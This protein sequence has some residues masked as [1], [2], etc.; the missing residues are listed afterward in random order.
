MAEA[1]NGRQIID[2]DAD[3]RFFRGSPAGAERPDFD[4]SAWREV[5]VPHDFGVEGRF[6]RN[7]RATVGYL[8]VGE[9]W[10]RKTFTI[11]AAL[12][13]KR[14]VL[15]FDGVMDRSEIWLNGSKVGEHH[16]GYT[17]FQLDV[18]DHLRFG[19]ETNVVTVRAV[20]EEPSS[21]WYAGAG[22][23]RDITLIVTDPIHVA[24]YGTQITTPTLADDVAHGV[25][26]VSVKTTVANE[27]DATANVAVRT[28][29]VDADGNVVA[30]NAAQAA[31]EPTDMTGRL[32]E[33]DGDDDAAYAPRPTVEQTLGIVDPKL[34][35]TSDPYQYLA[36]TTVLAA[37]GETVL[38]AYETRFGLRWITLDP[39]HGLF[40]NGVNMR[41]L[42]MCMHHDQGALG[43]AA[44]P[45][46][47]TRQLEI[48]KEGGV[49][50]IR[51][52]HNPA[53][54]T[55]I[56]ECSR[57]GLL[58]LEEL[59]DMWTAPKNRNDYS[60]YFAVDYPEDLK[61]MILRDRNEPSVFM[62]GMGNEIAWQESELSIAEDL[63][64]RCHLL[65]PT[66]PNSVND[67][68]YLSK[69]ID[70][71]GN[72]IH[73]RMDTRGYSYIG[74]DKMLEVHEK[75]PD[76][77]IVNSESAN[78]CSN[79][80]YYVYPTEVSACPAVLPAID[81]SKY[82]FEPGRKPWD[83]T[84]YELSCY[85]IRGKRG[86]YI[87]VAFERLIHIPFNVGEFGWTGFDYI[88]EP[89]PYIS[90]SYWT[91][92]DMAE[93]DGTVLA[94]LR[95]YYGMVDTAGIPKDQW[96]I[97][98]SLWTDPDDA[99]MVHLLP[100]WNWSVGEAVSVW[101][102][103]NAASAELFLNGRSL[104][105]REF[106][107][108]DT[109]FHLDASH[110]D[111]PFQYRYAK[112]N[113]TRRK[114]SLDWEVPFE[115][116]TIEVVARDATGRIVARDS[117]TT[118]G[119]PA[120][121]R[122]SADRH[123]IAGD[124]KDLSYVTA[125]VTDDIGV[126]VPRADDEV[127]F[128]VEHGRLLGTDNG[129]QTNTEPLQS[130]TH[131]AYSGL[132]VAIVA[133]DGSGLP[134]RVTAR[135]KGLKKASCVIA[136]A[137]TV[138]AGDVVDVE[139]VAVRTV[140]GVAP[141]LP[142]T[143]AVRFGDGSCRDVPVTWD[144]IDDDAYGKPDTFRVRGVIDCGDDVSRETF[145]DVV[146][147]TVDAVV[148]V[149]LTVAGDDGI[150]DRPVE[151]PDEVA[152][153]TS[154]GG[155][156]RLPVTWEGWPDGVG[157]A[158][159]DVVAVS[160]TVAV[161]G[162]ASGPSQSLTAHASVR[163]LA[164]GERPVNEP[165][166]TA[167]RINGKSVADFNPERTEYTLT[168]RYDQPKPIIEAEA[169]GNN[170][171]YILPPSNWPNGAYRVHVTGEDGK[172][173]RVYT[174]GLDIAPAPV[175]NVSIN[176]TVADPVEDTIVPL[177]VTATDTN[178]LP[179]DLD[180]AHVVVDSSD[181]AVLAVGDP[182]ADRAASSAGGDDHAL[183]AVL[184]GT[185][186]VTA[187]VT[188]GDATVTSAPLPITVTH[189]AQVKQPVVARDV[190]LRTV[191]GEMP[192]LPTTT[193]VSFD[194]GFDAE[195]PVDWQPIPS[196]ALAEPGLVTVTGTVGDTGLT[197][198]ATIVVVAVS[199][200]SNVSVATITHI[201]PDLAET[202]PTVAVYWSDGLKEE[203]PVVWD[204]IDET[205]VAVQGEFTVEGTVDG[206]TGRRA[207]AHVRVT[208]DHV[209]NRDLF[210]FRNDVYPQVSASYTNP[211]PKAQEDVADLM[212]GTVSYTA[213]PGY[214]LKNRWSTAGDP[215]RTAWLEY[216]FGYGEETP[217]MLDSFT[218][219]YCLDGDGVVLPEHVEVE[220]LDADGSA[221]A[222]VDGAASWKPV[223]GL[224]VT[225]HPVEQK[226]DA[227]WAYATVGDKPGSEMVSH[228]DE[229]TYAFEMVRTSRIRIT[230]HTDDGEVVAITEVRGDAQIPAAHGD[231]ELAGIL[232]GGEPVSFDPDVTTYASGASG[233]PG[234][235]SQVTVEPVPVAGSNAAITVVPPAV[236]SDE[237]RIIV[238]SEDH[239]T[240]RTYTVTTAAG[241]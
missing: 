101:A 146:V 37:D 9:G 232:V 44:Y 100:H 187:T 233:V 1:S 65:D 175:A 114:L 42:G 208:D 211:D 77:V 112:V 61:A 157:A 32:V 124:G 69:G 64:R 140:V 145:A 182:A 91:K 174:I 29:I 18:T 222:S 142:A 39:Q 27:T 241:R 63:T 23:Y 237:T 164:D 119:S 35:S 109:D 161:P 6:S 197:A 36:K 192:A 78:I 189:G 60:N 170:L 163:I 85:N 123:V 104:G 93:S 45:R 218:V 229:T 144:A 21:R 130:A 191:T 200:V 26:N 51:T 193:T 134:I 225:H 162:G 236:G 52:S 226:N 224:S 55:Q 186:N 217:F 173:G 74:K 24:Q 198:R 3:W 235:G 12:A 219:Y 148:P 204:A 201:V 183:A 199:A 2:F 131:R 154:D 149:A 220:Y 141:T 206:L 209:Q 227:A 34:W 153:I 167:L 238:T 58:V 95:S 113:P 151:L 106:D 4:D 17:A 22:L 190:S 83:D 59:T 212:D 66:R 99:P 11:P 25:A 49:N 231:A 40:L 96:Y 33:S 79:R 110:A 176:A 117:K 172:R 50:A 168:Q 41:A 160:G 132:V 158:G 139:P 30:E 88:G 75:N 216:R 47:V 16:Y 31:V 178:G 133:S 169:E 196:D 10:Y 115:P 81:T 48:M 94:P 203:L 97:Y 234:D 136:V 103:T 127:T 98:K 221:G 147:V 152:A 67:A 135:G 46:A 194:R 102:Y 62:W 125:A 230:F 80:G 166:L 180:D 28:V 143:A 205:A 210:S 215:S 14:F 118:P 156:V 105:V 111:K 122:L 202:F 43:A 56:A 70:G 90:N 87:D 207:V 84:T 120:A 107:S 129:S 82:E 195:I 116:G 19:D 72:E 155:F 213:R 68:S 73:H 239:V 240:T 138:A 150:A 5:T 92:P 121:L 223:R 165:A 214:N 86:N 159:S 15:D 177:V 8:K 179:I 71:I 54:K 181:H 53:C 76:D 128:S 13:G 184:A 228:G 185:A 57:L 89:A 171:V 137:G 38:D 7:A 108:F 126:T 188:Y 20:N